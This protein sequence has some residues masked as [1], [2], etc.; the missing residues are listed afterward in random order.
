MKM[1]LVRICL[2]PGRVTDEEITEFLNGGLLISLLRAHQ[3]D[4]SAAFQ[5]RDREKTDRRA[6]GF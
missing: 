2:H 3:D 1:C 5:V 4:L 6:W